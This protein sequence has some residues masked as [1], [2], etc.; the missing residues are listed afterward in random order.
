MVFE[1]YPDP[2]NS[3]FEPKKGKNDPELKSKSK[4]TQLN[5]ISTQLQL[6]PIP[7][8][9]NPNLTQR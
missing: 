1:P 3:P 5:P 4:V 9:L 6:N 8:Q 7:T 2:K